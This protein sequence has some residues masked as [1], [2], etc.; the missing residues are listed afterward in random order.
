MKVA[1][2]GVALA[3]GALLACWYG[4]TQ[5]HRAA[6]QP[7]APEQARVINSLD[8]A[9][10]YGAYCAVCHGPTAKGDGPMSK[11]L[12]VKTPDLT[13]IAERHGGKFPRA[14]MD[15]IISGEIP[16]PGGHGTREMP[17]WGPIFSQ[18]SWDMDLGRVRTD[19]LARYLESLQEKPQER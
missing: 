12:V 8:G 6:A 1:T 3:C 5:E 18:V 19:N 14:Q 15:G 10:L 4:A 17:I 16:Y 7:P 11:M 13:R 2:R 9:T